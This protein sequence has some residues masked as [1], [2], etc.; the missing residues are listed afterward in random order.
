MHYAKKKNYAHN[1]ELFQF[2]VLLINT[3]LIHVYSR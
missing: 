1:F 2:I 3:A